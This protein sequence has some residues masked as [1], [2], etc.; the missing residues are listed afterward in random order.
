VEQDPPTGLWDTAGITWKRINT[1]DPKHVF[2]LALLNHNFY[3]HK[4]LQTDQSI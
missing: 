1:T 3:G 2:A 4:F